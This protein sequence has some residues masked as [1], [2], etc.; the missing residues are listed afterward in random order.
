MKLM[1]RCAKS[2]VGF[3]RSW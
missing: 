2:E 1:G 3:R